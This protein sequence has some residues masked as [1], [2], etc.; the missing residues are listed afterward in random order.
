LAPAWSIAEV[1][2]ANIP[3]LSKILHR[4]VKI[5]GAEY[6]C[7]QLVLFKSTIFR[8]SSLVSCVSFDIGIIELYAKTKKLLL[9]NAACYIWSRAKEY[10]LAFVGVC[11]CFEVACFIL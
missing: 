11:L 8:G 7:C 4:S 9:K 1:N 3:S 10:I 5:S 6:L 2:L